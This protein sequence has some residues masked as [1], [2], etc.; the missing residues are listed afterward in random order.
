MPERFDVVLIGAGPAAVAALAAAP[1]GLRIAVLTGAVPTPTAGA[2]AKIKAVAYERREAAG[3]GEGLPFDD[4]REGALFSTAAEG[5][6]ANYWGQQFIR[7]EPADPWPSD[8]FADYAGYLQACGEIDALFHVSPAKDAVV[9]VGGGYQARTPRLLLGAAEAPAAGLLAMR[10]VF[11]RLAAA[12]EATLLAR[13]AV[14]FETEAE[15][16]R[17]ILDDGS[18]ID[19]K[20]AILAAGVVGG[21]RLIMASCSDVVHGDLQDHSPFMLYTRGIGRIGRVARADAVR[22]L[23]TL[24]IESVEDGRTRFFASIYRMSQAPMSLLLTA[25]GLPPLLRGWPAPP[26]ADLIKPVQLWT[27]LTR[28][29]MRIGADG[30]ASAIDR[31]PPLERDAEALAFVRWLRSNHVQVSVRNTAPG[32]GFHYH[33]GE[34]SIDGTSLTPVRRFLEQRYGSRIS[35]VDASVLGDIGCRPHT[36]TAMAAAFALSGRAWARP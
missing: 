7:Y 5:G 16:V 36:L 33:G 14:R 23:H 17:V 18:R 19:A 6:L 30:R 32:G 20:R 13:R 35:C 28:S 11:R 31:P 27:G 25:V 15:G 12:R 3:L 24:A 21:L 1:A 22:H 10:T 8:I 29:R 4:P 9:P 34:L 2:H 26:F